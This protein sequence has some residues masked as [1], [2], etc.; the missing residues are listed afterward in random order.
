MVPSSWFRPRTL[1][2]PTWRT[3]LL[4]VAIAVPLVL[5]TVRHVH[6]WL[7][8]RAPIV[9]ARYV[10]IEGWAPDHVVRSAIEWSQ[11]HE[12]RR[13]YTT[14]MEVERGSYLSSHPNYADVA[15]HSAIRMG[16]D[17]TKI[18]PAPANNVRRER[19]RAMA[20]ALKVM[21]E[22]EVVP[23]S[24]RK[25]NV[26]TL[27]THALRSQIHFQRELGPDWQVGIVGVPNAT[28]PE[29]EWWRYSEGAKSVIAE[30]AALLVQCLGGE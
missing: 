20:T 24:E 1:W 25:L 8:V 17:A 11:Q 27:S 29:A 18:V 13:I 4:A 14:G 23:P 9:D 22:K 15:A 19:T 3:C 28:Y 2:L 10:V 21:L 12:T 30:I 5:W 6:G 7:A 16:A 26:F